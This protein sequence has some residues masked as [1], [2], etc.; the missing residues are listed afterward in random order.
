MFCKDENLKLA[1]TIYIDML[2]IQKTTNFQFVYY[3][4]C[5]LSVSSEQ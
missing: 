3:S 2:I 4:F 5:A 1:N